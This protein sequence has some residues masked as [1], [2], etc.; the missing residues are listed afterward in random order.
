MS[1]E[2]SDNHRVRGG[3]LPDSSGHVSGSAA[4]QPTGHRRAMALMHDF[5]ASCP[6]L[7]HEDI[8][9]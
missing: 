5:I 7:W 4:Q 2:L 6:E 1:D 3:T 8:G 9:E